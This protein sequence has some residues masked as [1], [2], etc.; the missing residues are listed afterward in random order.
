MTSNDQP[1]ESGVINAK[2]AFDLPVDPAVW[3]EHFRNEGLDSREKVI[4]F[5]NRLAKAD[6][7]NYLK[8]IDVLAETDGAYTPRNFLTVN[9]G[10]VTVVPEE[11]AERHDIPLDEVPDHVQEHFRGIVRGEVYKQSI[12]GSQGAVV[13]DDLDE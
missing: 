8:T 6:F 12:G 10:K 13:L 5:A 3:A 2:I 1:I 7:E 4:A 9:I 11:W